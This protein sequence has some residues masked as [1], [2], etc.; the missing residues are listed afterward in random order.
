MNRTA[1][2]HVIRA[3]SLISGDTEIMVLGSQAVHASD[4]SLPPRAFLSREADLYPR[5]FPERSEDIEGAMG[6]LSPFHK[7]YLYYAD[8]CSPETATLAEGWQDR[9]VILQ[10]DNTGGA[11]AYCLSVPDVVMAKYA[12]NREKDIEF[13]QALI[14]HGSVSKK[15]LLQLAKTMPVSDEERVRIASRIKADFAL[16]NPGRQR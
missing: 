7:A 16:V 5:N 9:L 10:N 12:A 3:A 11:K 1:L 2:E 14:R 8:G 4:V 6:E 15:V 13:N